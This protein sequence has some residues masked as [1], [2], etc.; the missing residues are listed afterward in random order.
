MANS[1]E[2][3]A[4]QLEAIKKAVDDVQISLQQYS[5]TAEKGAGATSLESQGQINQSHRDL[6][7]T[8]GALNRVTQ[9]PANMV[10]AQIENV[11]AIYGSSYNM[12]D[13]VCKSS[14]ICTEER[15]SIRLTMLCCII[16]G[17]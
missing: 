6:L 8:I 14:S 4:R 5:E 11:G 12:Q 16:G 7:A 9:G 17:I 10:F 2:A 3:I 1:P 15:E 13:G